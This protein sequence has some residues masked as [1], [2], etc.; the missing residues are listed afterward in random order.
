MS[1]LFTKL[2]KLMQGTS[3]YKLVYK[4]FKMVGE[5]TYIHK[6]LPDR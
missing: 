3:C 1:N 2:E 6:L 4:L 5:A